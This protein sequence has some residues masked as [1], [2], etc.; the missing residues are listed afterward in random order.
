MQRH[1]LDALS[2]V[3]GLLFTAVAAVGLTDQLTL[4]VIDV[5]WIG[6]VLLV[7]IGVALVVTAGR[8]RNGKHDPASAVAAA[9]VHP[10]GE[11]AGPPDPAEEPLDP[12]HDRDDPTADSPTDR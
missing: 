12:G 4:T 10:T 11:A 8:N 7:A 5:R 3:F 1:S 9:T 2:L 6:P